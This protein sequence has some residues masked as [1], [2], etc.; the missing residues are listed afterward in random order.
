MLAER[1]PFHAIGVAGIPVGKVLFG[2]RLSV[3]TLAG[4]WP[5]RFTLLVG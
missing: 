3:L 5:K 1:L 2:G 4:Y